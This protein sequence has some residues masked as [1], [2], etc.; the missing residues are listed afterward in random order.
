M[1]ALALAV[2]CGERRDAEPSPP[3]PTAPAPAAPTEPTVEPAAPRVE[4][5][6]HEAARPPSEEERRAV[7]RLVREGRAAARA[8]RWDAALARFDQALR[9][10]PGAPRIVCEAGY[11]AHRAGRQESAARRIDLAL[12]LFGPPAEV[13]DELREPL[14]MCLYNRGLVAVAEDD[15]S[16]AY[17]AFGASLAL[18][19]NRTV[20]RALDALER[21]EREAE[22]A[23]VAGVPF[24]A[25]TGVLYTSDPAALE[26]ALRRGHMGHDDFDESWLGPASVRQHLEVALPGSERPAQVYVVEN[27]SYPYSEEL[28]V[29]ALPTEEGYAIRSDVLG[30]WD[31]TDHGHDGGSRIGEASARMEGGLL[32]VELTTTSSEGHTN[33]LEENGVSCDGWSS[34]GESVATTAWMCRIAEASCV[35]VLVGERTSEPASESFDCDD[36][37]SREETFEA[38]A[39]LERTL[40]VLADPRILGGPH[41]VVRTQSGAAPAYALADGDHA[42]DAVHRDRSVPIGHLTDD[43]ELADLEDDDAAPDED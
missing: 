35:S 13:G 3:T 22:L 36:G 42:F 6:A 14:A 25:A 30:G 5:P 9:Q 10:T 27:D 19:P 17:D 43:D 39:P 28:V 41:L 16:T 20:Q 37:T 24:D 21:E 11:V 7:R 23:R 12:R 8:E 38:A 34:T 2:G 32:R 40:A 33:F 15:P 1:T 4:A 18:R 31:G 29:V 26:R